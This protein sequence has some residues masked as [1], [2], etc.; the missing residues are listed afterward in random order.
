MRNTGGLVFTEACKPSNCVAGAV[1]DVV[2]V[3]P[4][5]VHSFSLQRSAGDA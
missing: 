4:G 2:V 5:H 3:P 1:G